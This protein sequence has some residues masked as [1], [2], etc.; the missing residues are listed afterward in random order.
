MVQRGGSVGLGS[1]GLWGYCGTW[2]WRS[3]APSAVGG[4]RSVYS[5][6]RKFIDPV[7]GK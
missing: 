7:V 1:V 2:L 5:G 3:V 4:G 6:G